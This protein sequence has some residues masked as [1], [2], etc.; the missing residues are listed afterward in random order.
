MKLLAKTPSPTNDAKVI[1]RQILYPLLR[2]VPILLI[3]GGTAAVMFA[4]AADWVGMGGLPGLGARQVAL[5]LS[6]ASLLL[7]G[8]TFLTPPIKQPIPMWLLMGIATMAVMLVAD[9]MAINTGLA[10]ALDKQVLLATVVVGVFLASIAVTKAN[11]SAPQTMIWFSKASFKQ[12]GPYI[13]LALQLY[14]LVVV[15]G[16][17]ALESATFAHN[18]MWLTFASF[19][20]HFFL[21]MAYRLPFFVLLSLAALV[22]VFG[23]VNGLWLIMLGVGLIL[24][25]HLPLAYRLRLLLVV[26]A[27]AIL[28]WLRSGLADAWVQ[29]PW[30]TA[31]WPI[32]GSMFM[33]R[34]ILYLYELRLQKEPSNWSRTLAYFFLLPNV[35]FPLFPVVDFSTFR[36]T[37]Y[38]EEDTRIYQTGISWM[39]RGVVQLVIYRYISYYW[40]IGPEDVTNTAELMQYLVTNFLLYLRVS[41][42]FHLIVGMLHLFGFNLPETHHLYFLASSFTDFWRRINIYWKDFMLKIFFYPSYFRLKVLGA[43][44][45]L[46][47]TTFLVFVATWFL[48]AY[49][50]F[51]LRGSFLLAWQDICFWLI[52]A[53]LVV[54]NSLYEVKRGRKRSLSVQSWSWGEL[55]NLSLRT[56]ATFLSLCILWSLWTSTSV[57]E[58]L[59]LW[60][61]LDFSWQAV[62]AVVGVFVTVALIAAFY[63]LRDNWRKA[64]GTLAVEGASVYRSAATA[65]VTLVCLFLLGH[66]VVYSLT[67]GKNQEVLRD[68]KTA[69]LNDQDAALLERGYYEDL[70]GVNRF[71]SQLWEIYAKR[72][73][74]RPDIWTTDAGRL[75]D[76]LLKV[77]LN[78]SASV[79]FYEKPFTT[80][81]WGMRDQEYELE[82]GPG[83]Y[84]VALLGAS[85]V[86]GWGVADD[87][88]FEW[89]LE[90]RLNR[91]NSG[92]LYERYE[93]LNF[94]VSGYSTLDRLLVLE[95]K[96]LAFEPDV[97]FYIGHPGDAERT[98][99]NLIERIKAG[100]EIP[101]GF[102]KEIVQKAGI[103]QD[104]SASDAKRR[105]QPYGDE[106]VVW[107]Y[108]QIMA[109]SERQGIL[110]IWILLPRIV[111]V[112]EAEESVH[113]IQL[114]QDAGFIVLDLQDVYGTEDIEV[115]RLE[116]W[117][118][119][120]NA[121]GHQMIADR[122]YTLL[123]QHRDLITLQRSN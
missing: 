46:V 112:D 32:L 10:T 22:G 1:L 41:G 59:S 103:T 55:S 57:E 18:M 80:N 110:P 68:L 71:N 72:P 82:K 47:V 94:A 2:L 76:N 93:I 26:V 38:N 39:V 8:I 13:S 63:Y 36:R 113:A 105:L 42:Q 28:V 44:V 15:T 20:I 74:V 4:F 12:L 51:W 122:L 40:L 49:Q 86:M 52:L 29:I 65:V 34:L 56:A 69:R 43:T 70:M 108:E 17:Y 109:D 115:I 91:E 64:S 99:D 98:I 90:D 95:E 3:I 116:S 77:E 30:S 61:V 5:A 85:H 25:C 50:W 119:H 106:L 97:L 114:A 16:Q 11:E 14:L 87:E 23:L 33:F 73:Q 60:S 54:I 21:P 101:F 111:G 117:D 100:V 123:Q 120:P 104:T 81:R 96:A 66:P 89:L 92:D 67:E 75:T 88:T 62:A 35:A 53:V 6:G 37:Y 102:V 121:L 31:I 84:R 19:L 78:P 7:A 83:I 45:A 79:L 9:M 58:W 48:H 27:A 24:L 107:A 118:W